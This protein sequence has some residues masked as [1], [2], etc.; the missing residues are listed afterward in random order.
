MSVPTETSELDFTGNAVTTVFP[1][2]FPILANSNLV[3]T[4]TLYGSSVATTQVIGTHYT[5]AGAGTSTCTVTML[6]APPTNSTLHVERTVSLVQTTAFRNQ[7]S[8]TS[9][10]HED[11]FDY[12]TFIVQ[13]LNRRLAALEALTDITPAS[14]FTA[15][16]VT[17]QFTTGD[18]V[19]AI[20]PIT[21]ALPAS[22]TATGCAVVRTRNI[23]S[24]SSVSYS[25]ISVLWHQT[26]A[27][28]ILDFV[29]GLDSSTEY[30]LTLEVLQ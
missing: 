13:E 18:F 20:F 6:T 7:G 24:P 29:A 1:I 8:F 19:N 4:L 5:V 17:S 16:Q 9:A 21:V 26:G 30:L 22:F 12:L 3:V 11:A 23:T 10:I 25:A 15:I 27:N 14:S 28:L 2:T